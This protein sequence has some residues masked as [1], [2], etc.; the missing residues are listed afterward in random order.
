ME[1]TGSM[2]GVQHN[3]C[4]VVE[5][6]VDVQESAACW[7]QAVAE[8]ISQNQICHSTES[9]ISLFVAASVFSF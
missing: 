8:P 9:H 4:A 1:G 3:L 7:V 5:V 2:E 6:S